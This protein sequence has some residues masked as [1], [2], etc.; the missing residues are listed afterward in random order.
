MAVFHYRNG[1]TF[2]IF[3]WM[4]GYKIYKPFLFVVGWWGHSLHAEA[5]NI[6]MAI[7]HP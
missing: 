1:G 2:I 3:V 4:D 5:Y 7:I 6:P